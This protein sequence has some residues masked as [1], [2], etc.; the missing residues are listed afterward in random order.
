MEI[1]ATGYKWYPHY[2]SPAARSRAHF[3]ASVAIS[4]QN[5]VS[6]T[7]IP[8]LLA[9]GPLKLPNRSYS[10]AALSTMPKTCNAP[11]WNNKIPFSWVQQSQQDR[12]RVPDTVGVTISLPFGSKVRLYLCPLSR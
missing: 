3:C 8:S 1:I 9:V 2:P 7:G 11:T 5:Y 4:R 6:N 12:C 10:D